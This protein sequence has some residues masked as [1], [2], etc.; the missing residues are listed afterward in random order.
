MSGFKHAPIQRSEALQPLSRDHYE[1]LSLAQKLR[2]AA[3]GDERD[4]L[5]AAA[6]LAE[7]WRAQIRDHF[8]EE[9]RLLRDLMDQQQWDR[10]LQEHAALRRCGEQADHASRADPGPEWVREAGRL[11]HDHIRWEERELFVAIEGAATAEQLRLIGAET[12]KI[13]NRRPREKG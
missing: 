6:A 2:R 5:Q 4:R 8:D 7:A 12:E 10:L 3:D 9:E 1:G 11:L 13:E